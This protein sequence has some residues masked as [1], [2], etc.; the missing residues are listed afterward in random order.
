MN[1]LDAMPRGLDGKIWACGVLKVQKKRV[2]TFL[3]HEY[4]FLLFPLRFIRTCDQSYAC[5]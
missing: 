3:R 1:N 2:L 5:G 4:F